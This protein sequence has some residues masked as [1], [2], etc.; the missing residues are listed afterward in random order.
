MNREKA[1]QNIQLIR[2]IQRALEEDLF[3]ITY[4]PILDTSNP[5]IPVFSISANLKNN[6]GRL[7]PYRTLRKLAA[8]ANLDFKLDRWLAIKAQRDLKTLH[9]ARPDARMFVPQSAVA[10]EVGDYIDWLARQQE[11]LETTSKGLVL[12]FRLS[13]VSKNAKKAYKLFKEL[14]ALNIAVCLNHFPDHP[15]ATKMLSLLDTEYVEVSPKLL[16]ANRKAI[17]RYI[18]GIRKNGSRILIAGIEELDSID[19]YWSE[20]ADLLSGAYIH[21]ET[22]NLSFEFPPVIV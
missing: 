3:H 22:D 21:P 12:S 16:K 17:N 6:K 9:R 5:D 7:L 19:L 1:D 11:L 13:E 2:G 18:S 15:A 20:G 8:S 4:Q 14:K 10:L